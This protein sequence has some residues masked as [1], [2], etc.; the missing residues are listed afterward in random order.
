[1]EHSRKKLLKSLV[2]MGS[3]VAWSAGAMNKDSTVKSLDVMENLEEHLRKKTSK[4]KELEIELRNQK[5]ALEKL[6]QE[7]L[8]LANKIE[9]ADVKNKQTLQEREEALKKLRDEKEFF[10]NQVNQ[11]KIE[12]Q[13]QKEALEKLG[14]EKAKLEE[15]LKLADTEKNS[16][17][18]ERVEALKKLEYE[19]K[20]LV[21]EHEEKFEKLGQEKAKLEERLKL[22][23]TEKNS[24]LQERVEALKKLEYEKKL[25]VKEHEEKFKKLEQEQKET[26]ETQINLVGVKNKQAL[27]EST[28]ALKKAEAFKARVIYWSKAALF[29]GLAVTAVA[30]LVGVIAW[31]RSGMT[32][33]RLKNAYAVFM[34]RNPFAS[35]TPIVTIPLKPKI[36]EKKSFWDWATCPD[37]RRHA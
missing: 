25:L 34:G 3:V 32:F 26:L 24:V 21:K 33:D 5:E 11:R 17:L 31:R 1:M 18:Q 20:L 13:N 7:K 36:I 19:K 30:A 35:S 27:Q 29:T 16:V 37:C 23:D 9:L 12:L 4:I 14:Q 15:R 28:E 2:I 22:A 10:V 8:E 6:G